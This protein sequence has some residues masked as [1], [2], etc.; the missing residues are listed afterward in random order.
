VGV[1]CGTSDPFSGIAGN[2]AVGYLFDR[3]VD[4]GGTAFFNET[5]EV[6]GAEHIVVRRFT[7]SE[8]AQKFLAL[9]NETEDRAKATGQD[10][11][12]INPIPAN[13]KA[14]ITTLEEKSLG[15]IAKSGFKPIQ[16][17]LSYGERPSKKGLYFMDGWPAGNSLFLGLA[18]GGAQIVIYQLGGQDLPPVDPPV[19]ATSSGVVAPVVMATGNPR[20]YA[21]AE[22]NIDF[23]AGTVIEGKESIAQAGERLYQLILRFASGEMTKAETFIYNE[24]VELPFRGP[25]L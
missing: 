16:A 19:P 17:V 20:T 18:C 22:N 3:I 21:K 12:T 5:P 2:P 13:I 15:A 6:I 23:S 9:V 8:M 11:R 14:G 7:T 4:A 1:K 25:L 10:I 24:P